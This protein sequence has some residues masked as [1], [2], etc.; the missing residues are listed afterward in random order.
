[1]KDKDDSLSGY[2]SEAGAEDPENMEPEDAVAMDEENRRIIKEAEAQTADL[3]NH[4]DATVPTGDEEFNPGSLD[5]A[6]SMKALYEKRS[7]TRD[8][9][10]ELDAD[11]VPDVA[12]IQEMVSE[13]SGGKSDGSELMD[14]SQGEGRALSPMERMAIEAAGG[15]PEQA[16]R[17]AVAAPETVALQENDEPRM[18]EVTVLGRQ[19]EVSQQDIDDAG[20]IRAYQKDRAATIR[21]QRA[22]TA[23]SNAAALLAEAERK[24]TH[25][26]QPHA[27]PS[28][29][30]QSSADIKDLREG[31]YDVVAEGSEEEIN[32]WIENVRATPR[33]PEPAT[34]T[35]KE[36][37]QELPRVKGEAEQ[38]LERQLESDRIEANKM[39]HSE[40]GDIM[41]DPELLGLA[42]QR[43]KAI[44]SHPSS[45]GR[46]QKAIAREAA[47]HVRDILKRNAPGGRE[48]PSPVEQERRARVTRKRALPQPSKADVPVSANPS[49]RK[50][51]GNKE[52]LR[53][54]Q[55]ASGQIV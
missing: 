21:L 51:T 5:H 1:M 31:L 50:I 25:E 18:V 41:R 14:T 34:E 15:D 36:E 9:Q 29:D 13:A 10:T 3:T 52:H 27:D 12:L 8:T 53:R 40:Y 42:Q 16:S 55:K 38:D 44:A 22:A 43:F 4:D 23:E 20:G 35:V 2:R 32:A 39:M 46:S 17:S 7:R 11:Q 47:N 30:G 26:E 33:Q 19:Y 45:E 48:Q 28:T 37:T 6:D 24:T 54:L 49:K